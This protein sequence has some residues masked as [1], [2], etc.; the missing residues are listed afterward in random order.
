[1]KA[2]T[3]PR[4]RGQPARRLRLTDDQRR[5]LAAKG[6]A[7]GRAVLD[8]LATPDTILA[9]HRR[10]IAAKWT[11]TPKAKQPGRPP[12]MAK[13]RELTVRMARDNAGWGYSRLQGALRHL[14]HVVAR[15]AIA[16]ILKANGIQPVPRAR[17]A[18]VVA[19]VPQGPRSLDPTRTTKATDPPTRPRVSHSTRTANPAPS[20][21]MEQ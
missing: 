11:H 13:I 7:L 15:T 4:P 9:W 20:P 3:P 12:V 8:A 21:D 10:L 17:T 2:I 5:R 14:G 18:D 16:N 1:M 6:K 19:H